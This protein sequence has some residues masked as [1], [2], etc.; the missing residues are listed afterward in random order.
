MRKVCTRGR[1]LAKS[2]SYRG[3]NQVLSQIKIEKSHPKNEIK[4]SV[5]K[6]A[7]VK[8]NFYFEF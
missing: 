5:R 3:K 4:Q 2:K 1:F 7:D 6:K 8:I